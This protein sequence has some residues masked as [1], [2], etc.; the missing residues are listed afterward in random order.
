MIL[1]ASRP[2]EVIDIVSRNGLE[3]VKVS[4]ITER[5]IVFDLAKSGWVEGDSSDDDDEDYESD[6]ILKLAFNLT[7]LAKSVRA[8]YR[9]PTVRLVLPRIHLRQCKKEVQKVLQKIKDLGV[10]LET[11]DDIPEHPLPI[12]DVRDRMIPDPFD[13]LSDTLNGTFPTP[14]HP[15]D[16]RDY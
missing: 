10:I 3:W 4:T 7:K 9:N 5:R 11:A 8:R 14:N 12:S 15:S 6:G 13:D 2:G 16:L 1:N